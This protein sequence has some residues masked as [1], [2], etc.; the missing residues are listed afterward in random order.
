MELVEQRNVD[1]DIHSLRTPERSDLSKAFHDGT[2]KWFLLGVGRI[3]LIG[4][5]AV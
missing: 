5:P 4:F 3:A 1:P 2:G